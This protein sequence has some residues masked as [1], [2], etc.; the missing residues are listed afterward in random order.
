MNKKIFLRKIFP[1][2]VTQK[3]KYSLFEG[4]CRSSLQ[5]SNP[6]ILSNFTMPISALK[7][8][9]AVFTSPLLRARQSAH[10]FAK[11]SKK[12]PVILH[13]LCEVKFDLK[14]LITEKEFGEFGDDLVRERFLRSFINDSLLESR[15]SIEQR[16]HKL[17]DFLQKQPHDAVLLVSHSFFMKILACFLKEPTL[18]QKP[19][20]L[21]KHFP[22][23]KKT[24]QFGEGFLFS[25]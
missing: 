7:N 6:P 4:F 15:N 13:E 2:D 24:Y 16:I 19:E 1:Y 8:V 10:Y 22:T 14:A 18:F 11:S 17:L 12:S 25:L 5:I 21:Q 23:D 3:E 9:D 20:V